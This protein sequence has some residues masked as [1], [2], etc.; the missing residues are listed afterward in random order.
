MEKETW[1]SGSDELS[2][3]PRVPTWSGPSLLLQS[4]L[5]HFS[6][7]HG[8]LAP[9][10]VASVSPCSCQKLP[11]GGPPPSCPE[12]AHLLPF[13]WLQCV[14]LLVLMT[15]RSYISIGSIGLFITCLS[16]CIEFSTGRARGVWVRLYPSPHTL[17]A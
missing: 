7:S 17:C 9:V 11:L 14:F 13:L 3:D 16:V 2:R 15:V 6:A 4:Y 1:P 5:A 12:H 8:K 10:F